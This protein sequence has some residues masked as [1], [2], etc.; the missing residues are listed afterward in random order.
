MEMQGY[1]RTCHMIAWAAREDWPTRCMGF[2]VVA[3][4]GL[5]KSKHFSISCMASNPMS[6]NPMTCTPMSC[7][8][9]TCTSI[10]DHRG[11]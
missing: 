5:M 1:E 2:P 7:Y 3:E 8:P 4:V 6:D 9:M 11:R 10:V